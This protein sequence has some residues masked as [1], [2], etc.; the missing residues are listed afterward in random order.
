MRA[1]DAICMYCGAAYGR[2]SVLSRFCSRR[3]QSAAWYRKWNPHRER[4]C[5]APGCGAD[6]TDRHG[7]VRYCS[8]KC[9]T[10]AHAI[11][12]MKR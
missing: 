8:A 1:M 5:A 12:E 3:C 6:V 2:R 4:V 11:K 10:A 9:K 7:N